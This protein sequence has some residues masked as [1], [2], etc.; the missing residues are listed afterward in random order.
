[1]NEIHQLQTVDIRR[2]FRRTVFRGLATVFFCAVAT[3]VEA[4][5][6][7]KPKPDKA[8]RYNEKRLRKEQKWIGS[9]KILRTDKLQKKIAKDLWM[10]YD[11]SKKPSKST[12]GT[13]PVPNEAVNRSR[14]AP[15][16]S[17]RPKEGRRLTV[18]LPE[19]Y[20]ELDTDFDGQ[21]GFYEWIVARRQDL[22][23]FDEIDVDS[24]G[25][26]TPREL[27]AFDRASSAPET[28]LTSLSEKYQR[29]R[30]LVVGGTWH[31][32]ARGKPP[33]RE[34]LPNEYNPGRGRNPDERAKLHQDYVDRR[35]KQL[36]PQQRARIGQLWKE[37]Q[38]NDPGMKN[39]GASFVQIME[40]VAEN[41]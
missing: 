37:K 18:D 31:L 2:H 11:K 41:E 12:S 3:S 35:L 7:R 20:A 36:T 25:I 4:D 29:P 38:K 28:G 13:Q 27:Q 32:T 6:I 9:E 30:L 23:V 33:S 19:M 21:I 40:Y 34:E 10:P 39:R 1:M 15:V 5:E 24:D 22:A 17:W 14:Y 16:Q 8:E 26:L